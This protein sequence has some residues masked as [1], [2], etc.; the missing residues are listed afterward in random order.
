[1]GYMGDRQYN[2]PLL[3]CKELLQTALDNEAIRDE[4]YCQVT[5]WC[6]VIVILLLPVPLLLS[7]SLSL[8]LLVD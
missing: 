8:P 5:T 3:L 4:V 7:T 2:Y 6:L 1:M